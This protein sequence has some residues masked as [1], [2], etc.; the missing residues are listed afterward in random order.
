MQALVGSNN[1]RTAKAV[2]LVEDN[3]DDAFFMQRAWKHGDV[4]CQLLVVKDGRQALDYLEGVGKYGNRE[5]YPLPCLVLLDWKL[6]YLMGEEVLRLLRKQPAFKS[7]PVLVLSSS[8]QVSDI[9][10]AYQCG[11]NAY[12]EKPSTDS[13]LV[14]LVNLIKSFWLE[15]IRFPSNQA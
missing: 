13:G 9:D 10:R 8:V 7:L 12:L 15:A 2:L 6:P 5:Q 14:K 1:R 3:E 4:P 11:A